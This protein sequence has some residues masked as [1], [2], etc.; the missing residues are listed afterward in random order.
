M[1]SFDGDFKRRRDI[2]LGGLSRKGDRSTLLQQT[3]EQRRQREL[4]RREQN[5]ASKIQR[6][7]R[8]SREQLRLRSTGLAQWDEEVDACEE[9]IRIAQE[10]DGSAA[11]QT[12]AQLDRLAERLIALYISWRDGHRLLRLCTL[13]QQSVPGQS[14][15]WLYAPLS[16]DSLC[17]SWRFR[18]KRLARLAS[19]QI[20]LHS[21]TAPEPYGFLEFLHH[22]LHTATVPTSNQILADADGLAING[23]F[24]NLCRYLGSR[25]PADKDTKETDM[26]ARIFITL[27]RESNGQAAQKAV[28]CAIT[29]DLFTNGRLARALPR[30]LLGKFSLAIPSE[31]LVRHIWDT[32]DDVTEADAPKVLA[33]ILA[34]EGTRVAQTSPQA[35]LAYVRVLSRYFELMFRDNYTISGEN[36]GISF[37]YFYNAR[38][39]NAITDLTSMADSE[40]QSALY[41]LLALS[42]RHSGSVRDELLAALLTREA[43]L[44]LMERCWHHV[45]KSSLAKELQSHRFPASLLLAPQNLGER[46]ALLLLCELYGRS[47]V[48]LSD[49]EFYGLENP[50]PLK[51]VIKLSLLLRNV[52]FVLIW[53]GPTLYESAEGRDTEGREFLQQLHTVSVKLIQQLH[54][55]DTR[56]RFCPPE[57]WYLE[58]AELNA[59]L[60]DIK[61]LMEEDVNHDLS[62]D[63]E[64]DEVPSI[65]SGIRSAKATSVISNG[66]KKRAIILQQMPFLIPFVSRVQLFHM[67]LDRGDNDHFYSAPSISIRRD[68][69]IEDAYR[70]VS[71]LESAFKGRVKVEFV[72]HFGMPEEG[73]DGGGLFKEFMTLLCK[74]LFNP[75]N[76]LISTTVDHK[77]YPAATEETREPRALRRFRFMGKVVGKALREGILL[78]TQFASFFLNKWLGKVSGLEDLASL[79]PE[80]HKGLLYIKNYDGN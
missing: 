42:L 38:H 7:W 46:M 15:S 47:L 55:R 69:I 60:F 40:Y 70:R 79:D 20:L 19:D 9:S 32:P 65:S 64:E 8:E 11:E 31:M 66:H 1:F 36:D 76:E 78:E 75:A 48:T 30:S 24:R 50:L 44:P 12:C 51:D 63:E 6:T 5:A 21:G 77:I 23:V 80:L 13:L 14:V 34:F 74:E 27:A 45:C 68:H 41:R 35:R 37:A 10:M 16:Y 59:H 52:V 18:S 43:D 39:I 3:Q 57:H 73:I 29:R 54:A 4:Q 71:R 56:R 17:R 61:E 22:V 25:S 53:Q 62:E 2:S 72:D 26:A 58:D 28:L 49:T 67:L 33:N